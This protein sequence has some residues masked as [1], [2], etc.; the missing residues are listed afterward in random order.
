MGSDGTVK[1]WDGSTGDELLTLYSPDPIVGN[2][3]LEF[4]PDDSRLAAIR[5]R[6]SVVEYVLPLDEIVA[7]A[8]S[9][10]TRGLTEDECR[11]YLHVEV[12]PAWPQPVRPLIDR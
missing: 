11:Q 6:N 12:C 10:L 2:S 7:L 4:S 3:D 1:V 5:G 8:Q 9:R